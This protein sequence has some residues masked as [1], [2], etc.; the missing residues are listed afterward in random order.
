MIIVTRNMNY[1]LCRNVEVRLGSFYI[2]TAL[3]IYYQW[4]D[5]LGPEHTDNAEY[6]IFP[7]QRM[8]NVP[9]FPN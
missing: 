1:F 6:F 9:K 4:D 3:I 5:A 7:C 2:S 8:I